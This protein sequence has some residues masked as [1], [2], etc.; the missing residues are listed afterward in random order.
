MAQR[1]TRAHFVATA[2]GGTL[3]AM[4]AIA[5]PARAA[6][7]DYKFAHGSPT[8]FSSSV[9]MVEA[10]DAIRR[11]TNGRLDVKTF[12][13]GVMGSEIANIGQIRSNTIQF[14]IIPAIALSTAVPNLGMDGVGFAFRDSKMAETAYDG[15]LGQYLRQLIIAKGIFAFPNA[16]N[17]GMRVITSSSRQSAAPPTSR[18][19]R[20]APNPGKSRSISFARSARLR[21]R[22]SIRRSTSRCRPTSSTVRRRRIKRSRPRSSTKCRST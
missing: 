16:M 1:M 10:F 18:G 11:E 12:P 2:A 3:A 7:F 9:R 5:A 21:L 15:P 13:N 4:G 14:C 20:F 6:Q 8:N 19:S 22:S 17:L